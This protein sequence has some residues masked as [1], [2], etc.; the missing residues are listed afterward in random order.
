MYRPFRPL[1]WC[2]LVSLFATGCS[3][4]PAPRLWPMPVE[5]S[6]TIPMCADLTRL[7]RGTSP[8]C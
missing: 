1:G 3:G 5:A 4:I 7:D 2:L 6:P 8:C